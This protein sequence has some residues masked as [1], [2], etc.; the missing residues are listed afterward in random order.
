MKFF[1]S[2]NDTKPVEAVDK[3]LTKFTDVNLCDHTL[4]DYVLEMAND[5]QSTIKPKTPEVC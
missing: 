2:D 1:S 4:V 5:Y 3:E